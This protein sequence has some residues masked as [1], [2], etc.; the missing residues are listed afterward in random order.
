MANEKNETEK[1]SFT[2]VFAEFTKQHFK[3]N[4]KPVCHQILAFNCHALKHC[5]VTHH[6]SMNHNKCIY[7]KQ[8]FV[9]ATASFFPLHR[10][11]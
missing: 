7:G 8:T 10:Y 1:T 2:E 4:C 6:H 11:S 9:E 5:V 3:E